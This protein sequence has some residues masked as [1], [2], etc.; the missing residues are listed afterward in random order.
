MRYLQSIRFTLTAWYTAILLVTICSLA[1]A[2]YFT[3]RGAVIRAADKSVTARL[4]AVGPFIAGRLHGKHRMEL[5]HEFQTHAAGLAP[6]GEMLQV[7]G[8]DRHWIYQSVSMADYHI[9]LPSTGELSR[10]RIETVSFNGVRLRVLSSTVRVGDQTYLVQIAKSLD[11]Y[12]EMLDHFQRLGLQFLPMV[13]VLSWA[14][15]YALCRHALAPIDKIATAARSI[16]A[17]DLHLRLA[18][19]ET[20]DELQRLSETMNGMIAR[21]EGSF[22]RI[23]EFSS[24]AAHELRTPVS[25]I[26]TTAELS[27]KEGLPAYDSALRD[28][29]SE[30]I[31]MKGVIDDLMTLA[32]ADSEEGRLPLS[33]VDCCEAVRAACCRGA[34]L[35]GSKKINFAVEIPSDSVPIRGNT[36]ALQRLFLILIENAVK[37]TPIQGN[38]S[39]SLRRK[40]SMAVCAVSDS[41][42]GVPDWA[43]TRVFDRFFRVDSA[44]CRESG[45]AGL[46]LAIARWIAD[47]HHAEIEIDSAP[48]G[49]AVFRVS[50]PCLSRVSTPLSG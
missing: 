29:Y 8:S 21:L 30:A 19:P 33:A 24:D 27:L 46:G 2:M 50:L 22:S 4:E 5:S 42:P 35:A 12:F 1:A 9:A 41:G 32:R 10:P 17:K 48:G 36:P 31:R 18:V 45:G 23:S 47:E 28:I 34:L 40:E 25:L 16:T 20:G 6:G 26:L 14:G 49:G 3:M 7:A 38:M 43:R 39:L 13:V 44:R 11:P 15:G 37:F